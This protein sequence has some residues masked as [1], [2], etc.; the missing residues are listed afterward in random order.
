MGSKPGYIET[1]PGRW[2]PCVFVWTDEAGLVFSPPKEDP[3]LEI[4]GAIDA[5]RERL[6]AEFPNGS[7]TQ[8]VFDA[9][10]T[11][12]R[13]GIYSTGGGENAGHYT[14]TRTADDIM[15]T[16]CYAIDGCST[17]VLAITLIIVLFI[18][19]L[20]SALN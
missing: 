11:G 12:R 14:H 6:R 3:K 4:I 17:T 13:R 19:G 15:A 9:G 5:I 2:Q 20:I 18:T 16:S 7:I 10:S 1:T 8:I